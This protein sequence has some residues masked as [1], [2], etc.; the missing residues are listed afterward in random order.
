MPVSRATAEHLA[1]DVAAL[2]A[3]AER[4]M[5]ER[6]ARN[7]AKGINGSG[8]HWYVTKLAQMTSYRLQTERLIVDLQRKASSGVSSALTTAYERGGLAAVA[9]V[10]AGAAQVER[11]GGI[12]AVEKLAAETLGNLNATGPRILRAAMDAYRDAVAAGAADVLLG[13]ETRIQATQGVLDRFAA[14]GITGFVDR[15]GRSWDLTSYS[16]M[17]MRAGTMNAAVAGHVDTLAANGLDLGIISA[18]GSP[19]ELCAEWEGEV[20]SLSGDDPN[21]PALSEAEGDGLFHPGCLHTVSAYQEGVTRDYPEKT[22]GERA[23]E[24]QRYADN[25]KLRYLE[26]QIR[27]SKRMQ[28]VALDDA[29]KAKASARVAAYQAKAR[30]HVATTTAVRQYAREQVGKA[31]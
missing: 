2:Y 13:A 20:V 9:E 28:A 11:L 18:D 4:L 29:A 22:A 12:S 3:E 5:L 8:P 24:A 14:K 26:R 16:E 19:C 31:H 10:G 21:Y 1:R 27:A 25:Q 7:L 30:E 6:I 17:A 23:A 15:A